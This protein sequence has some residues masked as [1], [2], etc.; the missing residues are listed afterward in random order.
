MDRRE[1]APLPHVLLEPIVRMALLEDL[2]RA[3]DVTTDSIIAAD[4]TA[5][6][7][8]VARKPGIVA[9]LDCARTA[10]ALLDPTIT[11]AVQRP[12][13]SAVAA[14]DRI[15]LVTGGARPILSGER[16]ALNFMT[17]LSGIASL[18]AQLVEASRGHRARICCTRKTLPGLRALQKYAVRVGGG[19]NHRFGLD[20]AILIKDNHIVAAGGIGHAIA[21]ARRAVGHMVKIEIEVDRLEQIDEALMH[22]PD[23]IL[24]DNMSPEMMRQAVAMIDGRAL[25]EASG[26]IR[27]ETIAAVAASGVDLISVGY[28]THS[29]PSLDIGLDFD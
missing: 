24:L 21:T 26:G 14:G 15:A 11:F 18:V 29:A 10:F 25:T 27:P 19:V 5:R 8:I 3:G 2:G 1:I 23:A 20:D 12:D 7:A 9:G 6:A 17:H 13:G 4:A 16:V 28:V 22:K